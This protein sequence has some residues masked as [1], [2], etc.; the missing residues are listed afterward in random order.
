MP[1]EKGQCSWLVTFETKAGNLPPL[2][3]AETG[4]TDFSAITVLSSGDTVTVYDDIQSGTSSEING[5]FAIEF[6][7]QRT[8]YLA[9]NVGASEMKSALENLSTI[10]I[11]NVERSASINNCH[12]WDV[13]FITNLGPLPNLV[14]DGLD[15]TGTDAVITVSKRTFGNY[16]PFNGPDYDSYTITDL[17]DLSAIVLNLDQGI[18]YF[19]RVS[20]ANLLG[21]GPAIFSD[22][23]FI[24]PMP[25]SP[26]EP[27]E[28][29]I[30]AVDGSSLA[31]KIYEPRES[32]SNLIDSYRIDYNIHELMNEQQRISIQCAAKPGIQ[33]VTTSAANINEKQYLILDSGYLNNG[34]Q[35]EVQQV[36]C[37]ANGGSFGLTFD[38]K[39]AFVDYDSNE[40][41]IKEAIESLP[42]VNSVTV[43]FDGDATAACCP[44][45][46]DS[47]GGFEVTF[48]SVADKAGDLPLMTSETNN[49]EGAR[50]VD[51]TSIIN[52]DAPIGGNFR[53]SFRGSATDPIDA[54]LPSNDLAASV[55][56]ALESLDTIE[57]GGVKVSTFDLLSGG[58]EKFFS[59]EFQG[60]G[61]GGDVEEIVVLEEH[62]KVYGTLA[63][64]FVVSD[65]E[66]Y[67]SRNGDVVTSSIGNVLSG[68]F[69]L[70]LRG[71]ITQKI[72][73][74]ASAERLKSILESLVNVGNVDVQV[75]IPTNQ[76]GYTWTITFLSNPGF[77]PTLAGNVEIFDYLNELSTSLRNDDSALISISVLQK[78]DA[79][80]G[81]FQLA[82]SNEFTTE[83]TSTLTPFTSAK[84]IKSELENLS[85]IGRVSVIRSYNHTSS[86]LYWDVE[87]I[88]C[89]TNGKVDICNEGNLAL[90]APINV[91]LIGSVDNSILVT[92]IVTGTGR[93][94]YFSLIFLL[95]FYL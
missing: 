43:N 49:L 42:N 58:A 88:G 85:N 39:T 51:I 70:K 69:R 19:F 50:W 79:L 32:S 78:G 15:L 80:G 28:V 31:V 26:S 53:L 92:E 91:N 37:Y 72:P 86:T 52:G 57:K 20:T 16:P 68:S 35:F 65:G 56:N 67:T 63:D 1:D 74:N 54:S 29:L 10:G 38:G 14:V 93:N 44:F 21:Y 45:D 41:L 83:K 13:T 81:T 6:N 27:S 61:V 90:L 34:I 48:L 64:A 4:S 40:S 87:F 89:S 60:H 33:T 23:P 94:Y 7:G 11:V 76:L 5:D 62:K 8:D 3:V 71:H 46:V 95:L 17:T 47:C 73:F 2:K 36:N 9:Y 75:S 12:V 25:Q 24:M 82:F 84:H 77:F 22:P 59:I 55:E 18:N 30:K 66:F